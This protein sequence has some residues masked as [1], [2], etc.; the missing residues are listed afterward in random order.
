MIGAGRAADAEIDAARKQC[1]QHLEAFRDGEWSMVGQHHAARSD[2]HV[3]RRR[4]NLSDHDIG[5]G[6]R[7][8][9]EIMVFSEPVAA[10]AERVG[11]AGKV[12]A[13]AERLRRGT[14]GRHRRKIENRKGGHVA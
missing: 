1:L 3:A 12:D 14:A 13:V 8:V 5:R 9:R 10:I 2:P 11:V 7:Y 4:R 6:T